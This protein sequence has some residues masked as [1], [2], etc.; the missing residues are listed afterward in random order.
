MGRRF[1]RLGRD[2]MPEGKAQRRQNVAKN[3]IDLGAW[4]GI[5]YECPKY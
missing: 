3:G 2:S 5:P 1:G 4:W